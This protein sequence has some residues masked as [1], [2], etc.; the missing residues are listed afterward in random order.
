MR[1]TLVRLT[2]RGHRLVELVLPD[3][4]SVYV[5]IKKTMSSEKLKQLQSLLLEF[6]TKLAY[7]EFDFSGQP[8]TRAADVVAMT[9][10]RLRGRPPAHNIS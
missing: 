10:P 8:C 1:R 6:E 7:L 5:A 3:C 9:P 4:E 2:E